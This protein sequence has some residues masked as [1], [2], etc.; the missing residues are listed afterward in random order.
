MPNGFG[1]LAVLLVGVP[2]S[3]WLHTSYLVGQI[4]WLDYILPLLTCIGFP[5]GVGWVIG[6]AIKTI[7][8]G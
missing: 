6:Y 8:R 7:S 3:V 1:I 2:L 5:Y 4:T